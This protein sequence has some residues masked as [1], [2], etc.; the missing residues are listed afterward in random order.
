MSEEE[1]RPCPFCGGKAALHI[2]AVEFVDVEV[3][4]EA[5][6][7]RSGNHGDGTEVQNRSAAIAAWNRRVCDAP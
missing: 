1:L 2:G 4:C 7:V 5:C 3:G 6:G